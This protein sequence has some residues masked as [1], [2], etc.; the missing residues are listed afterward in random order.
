[1]QNPC[2]FH[3]LWIPPQYPWET[4]EAIL[5]SGNVFRNVFPSVN[6]CPF[7][8]DIYH[9]PSWG[10]PFRPTLP[11]HGSA[12]YA[13]HHNSEL[14][15]CLSCFI[16]ALSSNIATF[17]Q[18]IHLSFALPP[19]FIPINCL[20]RTLSIQLNKSTGI[21]IQYILWK[22]LR[23]TIPNLG[24]WPSHRQI[25]FLVY[26][27]RTELIDNLPSGMLARL[28]RMIK[29]ITLVEN[30]NLH[31]TIVSTQTVLQL[32]RISPSPH[33]PGCT[34]LR[35]TCLPTSKT[36]QLVP[37]ISSIHHTKY[38]LDIDVNIAIKVLHKIITQG[39]ISLHTS[40]NFF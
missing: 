23:E 5:S 22:Q 4:L 2:H 7:I 31:T 32:L 20:H 35:H 33:S 29:S 34:F 25:T 27:A 24:S 21:N 6:L 13:S 17:Y 37:H 11:L 9:R 16:N 10:L 1:V 8:D 14:N 26:Y 38:S 40:L 28:L 15:L 18:T 19:P 39:L 30:I 3:I 36:S 12:T